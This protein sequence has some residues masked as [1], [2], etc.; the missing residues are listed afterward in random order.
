VPVGE[1]WQWSVVDAAAAVRER[2]ATPVDLLASVL[3]RIDSVEPDIHAFTHVDREG[4]TLQ[5]ERLTGEAA[6]GELRGPLHGVPIAIKDIFDVEGLAT[7]CGSDLFADAR[8]ATADA[9]VVARLRSAGAILVGKTT[10]HE[11]ACGVYTE[12]TRNPWDLSRC[13][14]GSSGGSGAAVAAGAAMAA[15][16]SDTGG[17]IR[18]PAAVCGI[19]GVKPTYDLLSR[20]GVAALSSTLDTVG[21]LARSVDDAALV[22]QAMI[23]PARGGDTSVWPIPPLDLATTVIGIPQDAVL[24]RVQPP[25]QAAFEAACAL[26][27]GAGARLVD[28]SIPELEET[29]AI[30]FAIVMAEA[31]SY[32]SRELRERSSSI[33]E[34]IRVLF[35]SGAVLPSE[36]YLQAQRLRSAVCRAIQ[37]AFANHDLDALCTP[38][39]PLGA[40]SENE[41]TAVIGGREESIIEAAVRTTAPFN[42]S[43]LPVVSVPMG[44][45]GERLPVAVQFVGEAYGERRLLALAREYE[46]L[47]EPLARHEN[48]PIQR[49]TLQ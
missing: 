33:S 23:D 32:Y 5:A 25:V 30:E 41:A 7:R 26:L 47:R 27:A 49:K 35:Q 2:T 16:G 31:A 42:L 12:G 37:R 39:L 11:L 40:Y 34:G 4:A 46:R 24:S 44:L 18:I 20:S 36:D 38:T 28:V 10:T 48:P 15:T 1:P 14:G 3:N 45:T 8:P 22:L 43:G 29:L 13:C 9:A 17:S 21:P 6:E 19:V